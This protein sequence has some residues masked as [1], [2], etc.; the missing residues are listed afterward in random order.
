LG[1]RFDCNF[2]DI[3]HV[4]SNRKRLATYRTSL[5]VYQEMTQ[6]D[7]LQ[8]YFTDGGNSRFVFF[9][10]FHAVVR[11]QRELCWQ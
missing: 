8:G 5:Q 10:I 9:E 7:N 11:L 4:F 3:G 1:F 6:G 2:D